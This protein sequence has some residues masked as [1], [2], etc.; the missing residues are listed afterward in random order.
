MA[1]CHAC[2]TPAWHTVAVLQ[3]RHCALEPLLARGICGLGELCLVAGFEVWS[4]EELASATRT[5]KASLACSIECMQLLSR[6]CL[7]VSAHLSIG[8]WLC[9]SL[10]SS[11]HR[12]RPS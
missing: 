8:P 1:A 6:A 9:T 12:Y 3:L 11:P 4:T 2:S 10:C 5:C 7:P